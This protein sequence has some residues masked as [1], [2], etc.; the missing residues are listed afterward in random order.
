MF[1]LFYVIFFITSIVNIFGYELE[2]CKDEKIDNSLLVHVECQ[3]I[4]LSDLINHPKLNYE[5]TTI[6]TVTVTLSDIK[7]LP[8]DIFKYHSN[9]L[10][11]DFKENNIEKINAN[12]FRGLENSVSYIDLSFNNLDVFPYWSFIYLRRLQYLYLRNNNIELISSNSFDSNELINL[13]YL[14]IDNN[15]IPE[16]SS[17]VFAKLPLKI[18]TLTNNKITRI[19]IQA[20]PSTLEHLSLKNNFLYEVPFDSMSDKNILLTTLDL[21]GNNIEKINK[22]DSIFFKKEISLY[23]SDNHLKT[24]QSNAFGSFHKFLK[25]DL[26]Y[27]QISDVNNNAFNGITSIKYLDL[28]NNK[29]ISLPRGVFENLEKSIKWFSLEYNNLHIIP[30]SINIL[31]V[32]EYLNLSNNKLNNL[33]DILEGN[34]KNVLNELL[35]SSNRIIELPILLLEGMVNLK[36]LDLSKNNINSINGKTFT[37]SKSNLITLNL[38]GNLINNISDHK[39]FNYLTNLE[40]LDLSY[41]VIENIHERTFDGLVKIK[42]LFFQ[43][44]MLTEFSFS[45]LKDLKNLRILILDNNKLKNLNYLSRYCN[46][47]EI[48]SG[49]GNN[50]IDLQP[51]NIEPLDFQNLKT[52]NLAR[53][54]LTRIMGQTFRELPNLQVINLANNKIEEINSFAFNFLLNLTEINLSGNKLKTISENAFHNLPKLEKLNFSGNKISKIFEKRI[55]R[56]VNNLVSLNL[57]HNNLKKF[58]A[59]MVSFEPIGLKILDLSFNKLQKIDIGYMKQSLIK[60][61]LNNNN[62]LTTDGRTFQDFRKLKFIDLSFNE[63]LDIPMDSFFGSKSLEHVMLSHNSI[64]KLKVSTF[65]DQQLSTLDVSWNMIS[66]IDE[67][68]FKNNGVEFIDLSHNLLTE[69]PTKQLNNIKGSL[70]YLNLQY[71]KIEYLSKMDFSDFHNITHLY[72]SNNNIKSI[73]ENT[74]MSL[75]KL[76]VL[77]ISNNPITS[78]SPNALSHLSV[79]LITLS[80]SNTGLFSLPK[81]S[82]KVKPKFLNISNNNFVDLSSLSENLLSN[83]VTLDISYNNLQFITNEIFVKMPKLKNLFLDGNSIVTFPYNVFATLSNLETLSLSHMKYLTM[84]PSPKEFQKLKNLVNLFLYD[85]PNVENFNVSSLLSHCPPLKTLKIE[86]KD[87]TLTDQLLILDTR[88]LKHLTI[89]GKSLQTISTVVFSKLRGYRI[90][91]GIEDTS[92]T[93]FPYFIFKTLSSTRYL[94]LNLKNNKIQNFVPF[95]I[96]KPPILNQYGT[97]L[98]DLELQGNPLICNCDKDWIFNWLSYFDTSNVNYSQRSMFSKTLCYNL[99]TNKLTSILDIQSCRKYYEYNNTSS[100]ILHK[101]DCTSFLLLYLYFNIIHLF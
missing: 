25:L 83:Q 84:I 43:E 50:I 46:S 65:I 60:I 17:N 21:D 18:L 45:A 70:K 63:I 41:N 5:K 42:Q 36:H 73:D 67:G 76:E 30:S 38:S 40:E 59:K 8:Q 97:I 92:I 51:D 23:L 72:L 61:F 19:G 89:T 44:N 87:D 13:H 101:F 2:K 12:A 77:D 54:K 71:N 6:M 98:Q 39:T 7:E 90:Y 79:N 20:F 53:N 24:L 14:H 75:T 80:L 56:S 1:S 48:F 74:F 96:T 57:S 99:K 49:N 27:N 88:K 68:V 15:R 32:L 64:S 94:H 26:S 62:L 58:N 31:R 81:I 37:N 93:S 4:S 69:V 85:L 16:I 3:K 100:K 9:I 35:L 52:F 10:S 11:L 47:L 86:I 22:H 29:I 55:F 91:L 34:Y 95:T 82:S 78:W 33:S 28:S 66:N